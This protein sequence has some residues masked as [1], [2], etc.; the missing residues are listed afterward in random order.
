MDDLLHIEALRV[1]F[2]A[3]G[4]GEAEAARG[5]S[6][7]IGAG[8]AVGLVGESGSGKS[9]TAFAV[10]RLVAPPGRISGGRV[11]LG[12][13]D[14]LALPET[15]MRQ[16][17]GRQV[18]MVFQDPLTALN[19]AFTVGTQLMDAIVAHQHVDR[20]TARARAVEALDLVGIPSPAR[21]LGAYPHEFSGGMR[22]RVV[23]A[24]AVACRPLLLIAD[25]PTTA[26]NVTI[27]AQ[28]VGLL[29]R[30][31]RELGLAVLFI[32][33][34]LDL[35]AEICDRVAVMYAGRVVEEAPVERLFAAPQHPY[36]RL[37]QRSIPRLGQA[38]TQLLS[39]DGAPPLLADAAPGC[40]FA[41]RC[42]DAL[43]IC[44]QQAPEDR[45]RDGHRVACWA[46]A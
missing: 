15:A 10:M 45:M 42:P 5:V 2:P 21:R 31:R 19:P 32:S 44:V 22:Q 12:G 17:R 39:I 43:A 33:H 30:L 27:Q 41:P 13:C 37:L 36:T 38:G 11:L 25:E 6:L 34:N 4:G 18:S 35:V 14:L 3:P 1:T 20:R 26:L 8:E 28:V 29:N 16:V 7:R 23:I 40:P 24:M 9:V 46:S